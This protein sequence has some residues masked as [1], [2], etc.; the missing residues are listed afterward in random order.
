[1]FKPIN[2]PVDFELSE[3]FQKGFERIEKTEDSLFVTGEAG[4]GKSTFLDYVRKKTT[5]RFVVLAPTGIAAVNS[6][7]QTIHS[8]FKFPPRLIQKEHIYSF[9]VGLS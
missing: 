3:E 6:G 2:L 5:K 7:G 8:F 1:M 9:T 4:T